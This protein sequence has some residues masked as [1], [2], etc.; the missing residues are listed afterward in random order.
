MALIPSKYG[1][2]VGLDLETTSLD[3]ELGSIL[4]IGVVVVSHD[5]STKLGEIQRVIQ[6]PEADINFLDDWIIE[7]HTSN[8]L[9][10]EATTSGVPLDQAVDEIIEFIQGFYD[11]HKYAPDEDSHRKYRSP[12]FGSGVSFDRDWMLAHCPRLARMFTYR[13][14]DVSVFY[15]LAM[16]SDRDFSEVFEDVPAYPHRAIGDLNRSIELLR[17][18]KS[19]LNF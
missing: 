8:G 6:Y 16:R 18:Y 4:E 11:Q 10:K 12:L 9:L 5:L 13:N 19:L 14:L 7:T 3:P 15:E 2:L 17:R 1:V